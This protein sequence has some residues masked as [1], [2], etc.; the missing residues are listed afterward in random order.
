MTL[1]LQ[2]IFLTQGWNLDLLPC[3]QILYHLTLLYLSCRHY[4]SFVFIF[5][6][7]ITNALFLKIQCYHIIIVL[8]LIWIWN[9]PILILFFSLKLLCAVTKSFLTLCNTMNYS[10][11]G[12][13]VLHHLLEFARTHVHWVYD[14]TQQ[15]NPLSPPSQSFSPSKSVLMS[16]LFA[17]GGQSIE[18]SASASVLPMNIQDWLTDWQA[19]SPWSPSDY[20]ES[21][22]AQFKSINSSTLSLLYGLTHTSIRDYEKPY[23]YGPLSA[24][25][26]SLFFN[27]LSRL[28]ITLLPRSKCL[29]I[30][31]LQSPSTV[32]LEPPKLKSVTV[33]P[34]ICHEVMGPDAMILVF[35]M[36]SFKPAFSL[37]SFTF[38]KRLFSSSLLSAI[39][40]CHLHIWGYWYFSQQ[41]WFQLVLHPVQHFSWCTLHVS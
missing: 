37:S 2:G 14:A 11:P 7:Q 21:S 41:S 24:K 8:Y 13:P 32:I 31:W 22:P 6:K 16:H 29:S 19:G 9:I 30:S 20:Q 4:F 10:M 36:L 40:W 3:R 17:S 33:S 23:L 12:F 28:V 15:S 1:F 38:I 25:Q 27:T 5:W 34:S 26:M 39:R 35:W 18:V